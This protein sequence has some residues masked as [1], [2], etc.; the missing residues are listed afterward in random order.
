MKSLVLF[1]RRGPLVGVA[2]SKPSAVVLLTP[3]S[4]PDRL[5]TVFN[6]TLASKPLSAL[7]GQEY[8][9]VVTAVAAFLDLKVAELEKPAPYFSLDGHS[10]RCHSMLP[11]N[12]HAE[13]L[14]AS[15]LFDEP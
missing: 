14:T 4:S 12:G 5:V 9:D 10:T 6:N 3:A 1:V 8:I 7:S 13:P 2:V 15:V 11:S